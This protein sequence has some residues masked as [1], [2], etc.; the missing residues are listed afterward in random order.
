MNNQIN[1]QSL[2]EIFKGDPASNRDSLLSQTL[3]DMSE[4]AAKGEEATIPDDLLNQYRHFQGLYHYLQSEIRNTE[5]ATA[6][7]EKYR[8]LLIKL[9]LLNPL[10]YLDDCRRKIKYLKR[11]FNECKK[12][13]TKTRDREAREVLR[14]INA[15]NAH[16]LLIGLTG[17]GKTVLAKLAAKKYI[18]SENKDRFYIE[19]AKEISFE[20]LFGGLRIVSD[21]NGSPITSFVPGRI[22]DA[23]RDGVPFILEEYNANDDASY[24][25]AL[26][27]LMSADYG[28]EIQLKNGESITVKEGFTL[29]LTG[30]PSSSELESF[31][32]LINPDAA[33]NSRLVIQEISQLSHKELLLQFLVCNDLLDENFGVR[34][35]RGLYLKLKTLMEVS[36][37]LY[38]KNPLTAEEF[39]AVGSISN[40]SGNFLS[41]RKLTFIF[42]ALKANDYIDSIDDIILKVYIAASLAEDKTHDDAKIIYSVL[43]LNGF[44]ATDEYPHFSDNNLINKLKS[45]VKAIDLAPVETRTNLKGNIDVD[46][47]LELYN[48]VLNKT[49][50]DEIDYIPFPTIFQD[51]FEHKMPLEAVTLA[52]LS[53]VEIDNDKINYILDLLDSIDT[54]VEELGID[55]NLLVDLLNRYKVPSRKCSALDLFKLVIQY[56]SDK[57]VLKSAELNDLSD[58]LDCITIN[59][60]GLTFESSDDFIDPEINSLQSISHKLSSLF[61]LG[62]N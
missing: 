29:I 4:C 61:T 57:S 21:V 31:V 43:Q 33:I 13:L 24:L 48:T 2:P 35:P 22:Y 7:R 6:V 1:F 28:E 58:L 56:N 18:E 59:M 52:L 23:V 10:A 50:T 5:L 40:L 60:V 19:N 47:F 54:K 15:N 42:D 37:K 11:E 41:Q 45:I 3:S 25:H 20:D 62:E 49:L 39:D 12:V 46:S 27:T 16:A 51:C 44:F 9:P 34:L 26:K 17:L 53:N 14:I 32:Q 30:N 8:Q 36:I 38:S 55:Q